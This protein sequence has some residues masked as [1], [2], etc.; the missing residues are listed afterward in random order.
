MNEMPPE[1]SSEL[2]LEQLL[3][4]EDLWMG[5]SQRFTARD[6]VPTGHGELDNVLLNHG[7]PLSSLVEVCQPYSQAEW[8]L[9]IPALK[10]IPGLLVLLNPPAIPFSQS[11]I[12]Q[13]IDLERIV[14]VNA[15][16]KGDFVPCFIE[17]AR[18]EVGALIAWQPTEAL[19]YT[20]LRKCQLAASESTGLSIIFRLPSAQQQTSPAT[21]RIFAQTIPTG[22]QITV[23]KQKGHLQ[24][25]QAKPITLDLPKRW[26]PV[27]PYAAL[28][29]L[30]GAS[31]PMSKPPRLAPVTPLRG[32]S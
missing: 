25:Q 4:R 26:K 13:G 1:F 11:L 12:Q 22:L 28:Y 15:P 7:W 19:T 8:H 23:F 14:V 18:A 5:H 10:E 9:L 16:D 24:T 2:S 20:D 21:V 32:K 6:A 31:R 17:M 3:L 29:Q 30:E 27:V